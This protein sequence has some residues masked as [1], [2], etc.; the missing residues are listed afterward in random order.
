LER[1][2][3]KAVRHAG[4]PEPSDVQT[5]PQP[6]A[7]GAVRLLPSDTLRRP[8]DKFRPFTHAVIRFDERVRGPVVIGSMRH[9]GL[10]LCVPRE[11]DRS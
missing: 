1:E 11:V 10:G 7:Q 3:R 8:G 2:V 5:S 6:F 4:L 9:Y